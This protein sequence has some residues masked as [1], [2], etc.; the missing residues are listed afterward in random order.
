M[1]MPAATGRSKSSPRPWRCFLTLGKTINSAL[2][3]STS[4]EVFL[5]LRR[6]PVLIRGLLHVRGGVS[7]NGSVAHSLDA[8]S[9]RPWRCFRP[10][11]GL[12]EGP[13]VFSTSVEVFPNGSV[14]RICRM[15]LLHV[16]GGV[17]QFLGFSEE[18][19]SSSPRPWR[20]F[21]TLVLLFEKEPV[22]STSV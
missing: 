7:V 6:S 15:R 1:H 3:F 19:A 17:S 10:H 14:M 22:F 4:V 8:S 21:P 12:H 5:A 16:R 20:C 18:L 13:R 11:R 9:P 2:V